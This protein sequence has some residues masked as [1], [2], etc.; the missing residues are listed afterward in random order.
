MPDAFTCVSAAG[1]LVADIEALFTFIKAHP[2]SILEIIQKV[3]N[4]TSEVNQVLPVCES[5]SA[6]GK[7]FFAN[8]ALH[9]TNS[10]LREQGLLNLLKNIETVISDVQ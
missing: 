9:F 5:L 4:L 2:T 8:I 10:T 6:E 3:E 1:T 7:A